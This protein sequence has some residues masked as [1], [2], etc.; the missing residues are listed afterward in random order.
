MKFNFNINR[1][2]FRAGSGQRGESRT[3]GI[4][5]PRGNGALNGE[6]SSQLSALSSQEAT[7][8]P[9][10]TLFIRPFRIRPSSFVLSSILRE[11]EGFEIV[12]FFCYE[13]LG[14]EFEQG[15]PST[16]QEL[17]KYL[18]G[19]ASFAFGDIAGNRYGCPSHL[20]G[21]AIKFVFRNLLGGSIDLQCEIRRFTPRD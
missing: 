16:I 5:I 6:R 21:R 8:I 1:I 18:A 20:G 15:T 17:R 13:Q 11:Y 14:F 4:C 7:L 19:V 12:Q 10:R 2:R 3:V 9:S